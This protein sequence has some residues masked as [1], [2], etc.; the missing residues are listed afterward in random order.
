MAQDEDCY[1][2][3]T[4]PGSAT[5][6]GLS[7]TRRANSMETDG[8]M[9]EGV[10]CRGKDHKQLNRRT[11]HKL[12]FIL[13]PFLCAL[14]LLNSLDKSNIGNAE[15]AGLFSLSDSFEYRLKISSRLHTRCRP[16][17]QRPQH[18]AC[19]L[20]RIL[21][22]LAAGWGCSRSQ[23]WYGTV[24]AGLYDSLGLLYTFACLRS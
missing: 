9:D 2:L 13:L 17:A 4:R 21:R 15:T 20:L 14:F 22:R 3:V 7:Q 23:V 19:F 1:E 6:E 8:L 5:A 18:L 16:F 12:D 11:L 10:H 24:C